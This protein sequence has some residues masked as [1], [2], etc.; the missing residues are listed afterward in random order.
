MWIAALVAAALALGAVVQTV[1]VRR[2]RRRFPPIGRLIDGLHVCEIGTQGPTIVF[3]AGLAATC[4]NWSRVQTELATRTQTCSYDRAGLGWSAPV[5]GDRSLRR[6]THDLHRLIHAL[7][8]PRPLVLTGH[9]FGTYIVRAYA[10]R[11]PQDVSGLVLIDPVTPQ[12]W[13]DPDFRARLR[14]WRA[15]F[16]SYVTGLFAMCGIVR[17]G[18]W[19]LLRRGAGNPGP[20]LGLHGT[21]RRIA[22]EVA[23][24]PPEVIPLL[25][26]RWSEAR[27]YRELAA[28]IRSMPACAAEAAL[29]PIPAGVPVIVLSGAHQTQ[30]RLSAHQAL[31]TRHIVVEGSAHWIHLDRPSLVADAILSIA[32][33]EG[34]TA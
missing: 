31:A 5:R 6:W 33:D 17:L 8:L 25:Q 30:E 1:C 32:G 34:S 4:L 15:A 23:K 9:S 20:L 7:N 10:H 21:L 27:F 16:F 19:G 28:S 12:E 14:L 13:S 2:D 24:L 22:R 18:L 29:H 3:E 11:F 26:A